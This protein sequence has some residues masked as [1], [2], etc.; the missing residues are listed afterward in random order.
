MLG[1]MAERRV[2]PVT[3]REGSP[4]HRAYVVVPW[5]LAIA[6]IAYV[7]LAADIGFAPGSIDDPGRISQLNQVIA[8][9]VA[10]LG[11]N[12]AIGFSGQLSLGQ[13]AFVGLGAYTTVI[14]VADHGWDILATL[15]VSAGVCFVVGLVIGVP[16]SRI[17]GPYLA[18]A[19]LAMAYVFPVIVDRFE[20][21]TGGVN[22]KGPPRGRVDLHPP[23][24]MP[25]AD[26]GRLAQP[27]WVYCILVVVAAV[28]FVLARN[29]LRSRPGRALLAVRDNSAGATSSGISHVRYLA[30]AF[31]MSAVYGGIAGSM[32]MIDRPFASDIQFGTRQAI[33]LVAGLVVGGTGAI[34]G[35]IPGAFVYFFVPYYVSGWLYDPSGMPPGL[36]QLVTPLVDWLR[37]GGAGVA[38]LLFG[39]ALLLLMFVLPGGLI[40]GVRR[41][42]A[43]LVVVEQRPPQLRD[44]EETS[45]R[46]GQ[47]EGRAGVGP[48]PGRPTAPVP[49]A[50]TPG[51][52]P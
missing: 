13:S 12:L 33:F 32:L 19:T 43:R 41:V 45:A 50:G 5:V 21:L 44:G 2:L 15:P 48:D 38:A 49:P 27:L 39:V 14:L 47:G 22:G 6:A 9:A 11:L 29:F 23:S 24:W 1:P 25:F 52:T 35:A 28:M 16:A 51:T 3:L 46:G 17:K 40:D 31:A 20:S 10:I 26:E 8:F 36:R 4:A 42:R 18:V 7:P 30:M 34:A 37:P